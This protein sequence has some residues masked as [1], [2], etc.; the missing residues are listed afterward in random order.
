MTVTPPKPKDVLVT[1][2]ARLSKAAPN[3]WKDFMDAYDAFTRSRMDACVAAPADQVLRAQGM[4]LQCVELQTLF[5][6]AV[7]QK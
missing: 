6:E 1:V 5:A 2:A 7:K 4:A 3:S